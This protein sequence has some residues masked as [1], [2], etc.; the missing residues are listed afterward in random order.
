MNC[1]EIITLWIINQ[2]TPFMKFKDKG[3]RT[4]K[5]VN[6]DKLDVTVE[7]QNAWKCIV[8]ASTYRYFVD[9]IAI[10]LDVVMSSQ[11]QSIRKLLLML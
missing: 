2:W 5:L 4:K 7:N 11:M 9:K 10:V 8:N 3:K 6:L 1:K